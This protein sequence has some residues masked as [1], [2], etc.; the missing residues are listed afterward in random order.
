MY[1]KLYII[2]FLNDLRQQKLRAFLTLFGL[3]WGTTAILTLIALSE[4]QK[5]NMLRDLHAIG[6][7]IVMMWPGRTTMPYRGFGTRRRLKFY[8]G[9]VEIISESNPG[10]DKISG[11]CDVWGEI[12]ARYEKVEDTIDLV[13]VDADWG[14]MRNMLPQTNGRFIQ[15]ADVEL[16]RRVVFIGTDIQERFFG[17]ED[18]VGKIFYIQKIPFQVIGV[19]QPKYEK[20]HHWSTDAEKAVIPLTTLM[21]MFNKNELDS[22]IYRP[23][24]VLEGE[25]VLANIHRTFAQLRNYHPDDRNALHVWDTSDQDKWIRNFSLGLQIFFGIVGVF[26]VIVAGIGVANIMNVIVEE[27]TKEIGIKMALGCKRY[28]IMLQ[29]MFETFLMVILGGIIG[30]GVSLAVCRLIGQAELEQIGTP[31]VTLNAAFITT[32]ILGIVAFLAGYFPARRASRFK[33]VE[34]L[35]WQG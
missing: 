12:P 25:Y 16:K 17:K 9:D 4:S 28:I 27:R 26:T 11:E 33:P 13:G 8:P 10:I 2:Q 32:C 21:L 3:I 14:E 7:N 29:F 31:A 6:E 34:A 1:I 15:P 24:D 23:T 5:R 22:I 18:P 35:R 30:F 20:S 19:M